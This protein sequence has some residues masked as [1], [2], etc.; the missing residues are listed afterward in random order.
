MARDREQLGAGVVRT[1]EPGEPRSTPA[2]NR[3]HHRNRFHVVDR[4]G[5]PQITG[6]DRKWRTDARGTALSLQR[7]DERRLFAANVGTRPHMDFDVKVKDLA[8]L[9]GSPEQPLHPAALQH[10]FQ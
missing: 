6:L 3:R 2:Q 4:R 5:L 8:T 7:L 10:G 1:A 9:N